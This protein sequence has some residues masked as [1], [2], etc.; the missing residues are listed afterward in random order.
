MV[1]SY[2]H[3]MQCA[4]LRLFFRA[5]SNLTLMLLT[6][7]CEFLTVFILLSYGYVYN[8]YITDRYIKEN[9]VG[10][11]SKFG[12]CRTWEVFNICTIIKWQANLVVQNCSSSRPG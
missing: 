3:N 7:D 10:K 11:T 9:F 5:K 6:L 1:R 4:M 12:C 2:G 8:G